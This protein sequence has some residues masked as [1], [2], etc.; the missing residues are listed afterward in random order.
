M[1][2]EQRLSLFEKSLADLC[3]RGK[4][5]VLFVERGNGDNYAEVDAEL[6]AEVSHRRWPA[7]KLP[8]L[9]PDAMRRLDRLGYR[10]SERNPART[11]VG[12]GLPRIARSLEAV[13]LEVYG[14]S[15]AFE[16]DCS[17]GE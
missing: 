7:C 17:P 15:Q 14:C 6:R 11:Y 8:P 16:L 2:P 5:Y 10:E 4:G 1:T 12:W 3:R 9:A 13:F